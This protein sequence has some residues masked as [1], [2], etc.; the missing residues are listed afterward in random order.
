MKYSELCPPPKLIV[1]RTTAT[2]MFEHADI[3]RR[4]EKANWIRPIDKAAQIDLFSV[5]PPNKVGI[6]LAL[7]GRGIAQRRKVF[8]NI[9]RVAIVLLELQP[10]RFRGHFAQLLNQACE[11]FL[12]FF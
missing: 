2:A 10:S 3:L 8:A 5:E 4:M 1:R 11:V 12:S 9:I 6:G 7:Q